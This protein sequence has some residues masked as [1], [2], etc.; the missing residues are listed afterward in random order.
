MVQPG[1]S[2]LASLVPFRLRLSPEPLGLEP[3]WFQ[4]PAVE[5]LESALGQVQQSELEIEQSVPPGLASSWAEPRYF[6][7]ELSKWHR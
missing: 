7:V 2:F 3:V 5:Q 1:F 6:G 4:Q